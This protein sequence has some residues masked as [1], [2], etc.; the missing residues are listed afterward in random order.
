[1]FLINQK[2]TYKPIIPYHVFKDKDIKST[3][4]LSDN[5]LVSIIRFKENQ[6]EVFKFG[7]KNF[8]VITRY[9]RSRLYALAVY[10]LAEKIKRE[11]TRQ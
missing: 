4:H 8:Y 9:N 2:K 1:M 7:H 3:S 5:E 10:F 11:K 6:D